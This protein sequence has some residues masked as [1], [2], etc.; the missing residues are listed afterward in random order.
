MGSVW[1]MSLCQ[2]EERIKDENGNKLHSTQKP[3]ELLYRIIAISSQVGDLVLDPFG[4]T[5][6]TGAMAKKLGRDYICIDNNR[7]Y[8]NYGKERLKNIVPII[9]DV[10]LATFDRKPPKVT[11]TEMIDAGYFEVGEKLYYNDKAYLFLTKEGKGQKKDG[12]IT[13]IH[14]AIGQVKNNSETRLNGWDYWT[15][16]RNG[17]FTPINDIRKK[18]L[19]EVK[20]YE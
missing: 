17:R 6:T 15:V 9:N 14:S 12:S 13:D 10:A 5:M 16:M 4:G 3:E 2:G 8:C 18:Y 19:K 7:V 1:K 11:F 20:N